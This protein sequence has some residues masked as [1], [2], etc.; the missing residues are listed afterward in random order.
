MT[1]QE[2]IKAFELIY[3]PLHIHLQTRKFPQQMVDECVDVLYQYSLALQIKDTTK[4]YVIHQS[5][6]CT[7]VVLNDIGMQ[8]D[9]WIRISC[10]RNSDF[11]YTDY[12][13][14]NP[15]LK[16]TIDIRKR[17]IARRIKLNKRN[18]Q[19]AERRRRT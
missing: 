16:E 19:A 14:F 11:T 15:G 12:L 5:T 6:F 3:K 18:D 10:H 8:T 17:L 7:R 4:E 2:R 1:F 9:R 13:S